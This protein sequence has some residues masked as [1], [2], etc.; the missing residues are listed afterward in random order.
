MAGATSAYLGERPELFMAAQPNPNTL[1]AHLDYQ[2]AVKT[3]YE[4][5]CIRQANKLAAQGHKAVADGC[6]KAN[7]ELA[8]HSAYL[9]AIDG[10][11][12]TLPYDNIIAVNKN[13][14]ILHY[15][16]RDAKARPIDSLLIDAGATYLGYCSDISRTYCNHSGLFNDLVTQLNQLQLSVCQ[17]I[18]P[19]MD[20]GDLHH[21][22]SV[23]I[24]DL[25]VDSGIITCSKEQAQEHQLARVFFPHGLGH[26]LGVQV[27]D[28]GG[29]QA[30]ATGTPKPPP[31]QYPHLRFTRQLEVDQVFTIE[32]GLYFIDQLLEAARE[33][34][35]GKHFDWAVI[36]TL[37][38]FGG[39]RIE[40]NLRV[41]DQGSE[42]LTR[43]VL[44]Q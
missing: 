29:H 23:S 2:Q 20:Y 7:S 41:T 9:A 27:H 21:Q 25:L 19:G 3:S 44:P 22:A 28:R 14:A 5:E 15:T 18:K 36:E 6:R 40:D 12:D 42:N 38:P 4:I 17:Q 43:C 31:E 39:I 26:L 35:R 34:G 8:L 30:D 37:K 10:S 11:D 32:P 24:G 1:I 16:L 13:S 33:D